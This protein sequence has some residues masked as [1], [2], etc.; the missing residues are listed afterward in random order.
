VSKESVRADIE[1]ARLASERAAALILRK[2]GRGRAS[3]AGIAGSAPFVGMAGTVRGI[4]SSFVG[5]SGEK[6]AC[7]A[8][9]I[10]RLSEAIAPTA[11]A[12]LI[13]LL[14]WWCHDYLCA[15]LKALD[16]EMRAATLELANSLSLLR[17]RH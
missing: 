9:V 4:F 12:L 6:S 7:M 11:L 14:A 17:Q 5:C 16:T 10:W 2:M 13:A 1:A 8:A 3:L 15:R